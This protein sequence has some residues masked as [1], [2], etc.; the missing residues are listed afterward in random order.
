M[1]TTKTISMQTFAKEVKKLAESI[2][3]NYY[4]V[5]CTIVHFMDRAQTYEFECYIHTKT[6]ISGA[7]PNEALEKM[8][9]LINPKHESLIKDITLEDYSEYH[10]GAQE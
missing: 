1:E 2:G 3:Q 10:L 5:R 8:K 7:T 6:W 9:K 4:N